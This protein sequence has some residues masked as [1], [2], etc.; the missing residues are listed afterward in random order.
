[1]GNAG[2]E[3]TPNKNQSIN[4]FLWEYRY[5][6]ALY[7]RELAGNVTLHGDFYLHDLTQKKSAL[8][9]LQL[10]KKLLYFCPEIVARL[11]DYNYWVNRLTEVEIIENYVK[12][13]EGRGTLFMGGVKID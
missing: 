9:A 6:T 2:T 4:D 8:Y 1:M 12:Y 3:F 7:D 13:R 11:H 5:R 10:I